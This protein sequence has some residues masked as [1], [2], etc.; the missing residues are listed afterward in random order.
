VQ[1]G[2]SFTYNFKIFGNG[3]LKN[4]KFKENLSDTLFEIYEPRVVQQITNNLVEKSFSFN[5]VPKFAGKF[6]LKDYFFID[7]FNTRN[8]TYETL[9]ANKQI[10]VLGNNI[11][12]EQGPVSQENNLYENIASLKSGETSF[13]FR[14]AILKVSNFLIIAMLVAMAYIFWPTKK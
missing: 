12:V 11:D 8:K 7:Y 14:E 5:I 13:D 10:E 6:S 3:N 4:I 2:R 9:R 1:T